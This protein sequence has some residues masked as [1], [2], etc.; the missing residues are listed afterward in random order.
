MLK[1]YSKF[2][3]NEGFND[4]TKGSLTRSDSLDDFIED[5]NMN[6][7]FLKTKKSLEDNETKVLPQSKR[8]CQVDSSNRYDKYNN[9]S[10]YPHDNKYQN[11]N[12]YKENN[13][14]DDKNCND[15]YNDYKRSSKTSYESYRRSTDDVVKSSYP[16]EKYKR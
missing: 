7:N 12:K 8:L 16:Y 13:Y 11:D 10:K 1:H 9:D 4:D 14:S 6:K 5:D 3:K 15:K 2:G